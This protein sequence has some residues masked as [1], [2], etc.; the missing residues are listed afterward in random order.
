MNRKSPSAERIL[1]QAYRV[2]SFEELRCLSDASLVNLT[3]LLEEKMLKHGN[4]IPLEVLQSIR[5]RADKYPQEP[6]DY[7][8]PQKPP[9]PK[10]T[11]FLEQRLHVE[12]EPEQLKR[13]IAHDEWRR[14]VWL[15]NNANPVTKDDIVD[16]MKAVSSV[17]ELAALS[18]IERRNFASVVGR[19]LAKAGPPPTLDELQGLKELAIEHLWCSATSRAAEVHTSMANTDVDRCLERA[20]ERLKQEMFRAMTS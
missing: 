2:Y 10:R 11:S 7:H 15:E 5:V 9:L 13:K 17:D 3:L 19:R 1:E 20:A 16:A 14:R 4:V 18:S 6:S 8:R 12:F